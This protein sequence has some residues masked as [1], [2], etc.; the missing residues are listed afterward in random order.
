MEVR[1][2]LRHTRTA[3]RKARLVADLIRGK[4]VTDAI[5]I[6]ESAEQMGNTLI[7][8]IDETLAIRKGKY[9]DYIFYKTE[10]MKRPQFLKLNGFEDDYKTCSEKNIRSWIK[11]KYEI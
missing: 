1:A 6:L 2:L 11:E 4:N 10:K 8:K 9:G 3:P 7:R 5:N